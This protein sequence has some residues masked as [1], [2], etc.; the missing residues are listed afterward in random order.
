MAK[1][2]TV[3]VFKNKKHAHN[4]NSH[5]GGMWKVAYADFITA[6]M[7]FFL[8]LWLLSVAP[9][10]TLKGVAKYFTPTV[11]VSDRA[12]LGFEGGADSNVTDGIAANNIASSSLIFGSPSRGRKVDQSSNSSMMTDLDKEKFISVMSKIQHDAE[13]K[14]FADNISVD[15]TNDGLRIQVMDSENRAMF[16]KNTDILEPYMI[17]I[18]DII[19]KLVKDQPNYISISGHTASVSTKDGDNVDY[20]SWS[21]SASRANS[22]RKFLTANTIKSEQVDRIIGKADKEP[23]DVNDRYSTKNIRIGITLLNNKSIVKSQQSTPNN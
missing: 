5:R 19:G 23:F 18:L 14:N 20:D 22:V 16:K 9:E 2:H 4:H 12:G 8:L 11:S 1:N 15:I 3:V 6:M 7:A 17:K 21:L 10:N 13:L